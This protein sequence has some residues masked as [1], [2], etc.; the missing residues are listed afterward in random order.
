[1]VNVYFEPWIFSK[2]S[3][4]AKAVLLESYSDDYTIKEVVDLVENRMERNKLN[5][6]KEENKTEVSLTVRLIIYD[7]AIYNFGRYIIKKEVV[8]HA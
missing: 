3:Y 6:V 8:T 7:Y 1:M 5:V 2:Y 4:A